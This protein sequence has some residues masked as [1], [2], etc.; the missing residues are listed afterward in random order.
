MS[1]TVVVL[2]GGMSGIAT[3]HKLLKHT[4]PK[5]KGLKVILVSASSH[6][7]MNIAAVRGVIPGEIP[8]KDLFYPIEPGFAKYPRESFE[9]VVGSATALDPAGNTVKVRAG[10]G[11]AEERTIA[12]DQLVIATGS[13]LAT[14]LP[15]KTI[16]SYERT[17]EEWHKLQNRIKAAKS[18]VIAGAGPT[19]VETMGELAYKY[20]TTKKLTLIIDGEHAL[21]SLMPSVAKTA[22]AEL[23]K[24]KVELLRKVR[25][26]AVEELGGDNGGT[27]LTLSDGK[28]LVA[29]VFLP[30]YGVR[31]NSSFV[32]AHLL[33]AGGCVKVE[34]SLRVA[35]CEN[36]WAVG[37]VNNLEFKTAMRAESQTVHLHPNL[38]A[39]LLGRG[40][41]A[42]AAYKP[43]TTTMMM[44][45]VGKKKGTGQIGSFKAFSFM[46]NF[47][48]GK[49]L[50][51]E[52]APAIV[53][54]KSLFQNKI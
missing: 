2:G 13:S 7:Y 14:D 21:P 36:V 3:A 20:G 39:V 16:G 50:L 26:D 8:D 22:E 24:M 25:V 49:T 38:E 30:L 9:F 53:D 45:P 40:Q 29:D 33:D 17:I 52:K 42:L 51:V 43:G 37:D 23:T 54:G 28:T 12:Y 41:Q 1:K 47:F 19:G 10:D 11:G 4:A 5:L 15:F 46:V 48:K 32:P 6:F 44:V 35:G 18:V 31:P 27:K 34:P